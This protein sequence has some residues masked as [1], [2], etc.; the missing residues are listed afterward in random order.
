[1]NSIVIIV[2]F[3]LLLIRVKTLVE[4]RD[5]VENLHKGCFCRMNFASQQ[6]KYGIYDRVD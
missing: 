5:Q 2:A 3:E 4:A 1:M 6:L